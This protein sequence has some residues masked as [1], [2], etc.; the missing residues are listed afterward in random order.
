MGRIGETFA[1]LKKEKRKA[2]V[3]FITAGD[4]DI[5]TTVKLVKAAH[6]AGADILE[7]G[8][9]FSDPLA[10]GPVIQASFH[11]AIHG[12][13]NVNR[14]VEAVA[15]IRKDCQVPIVFMLAST[16]VINHGAE[17]FMK[18]CA[19]AGVDGLIIP[20][21]PVDEAGEFAPSAK[22]A[23][24]DTILLAAPTSTGARLRK[25]VA[26]SSGFV[27]YISVTGVTGKKTAAV[28]DVSANVKKIKKLTKL[29]VLAGFGVTGAEQAKELSKHSDG[30]IIGSQAMRVINSAKSKSKAVENLSEFVFSVREAMDGK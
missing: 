11:R 6:E 22:A 2:L 9:P 12:G 29:P 18:D 17:R 21:A 19:A 8:V 10:D 1:R 13:T 28:K 3:I 5:E 27:Y 30:V 26:M 14:V 20:D 23:G 7:L 15:K 4:P 24:L 25:I 16:L